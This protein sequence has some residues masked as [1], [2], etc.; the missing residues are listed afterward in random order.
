M[1]NDAGLPE[2]LCVGIAVKKD[3]LIDVVVDLCL[4]MIKIALAVCEVTKD[5]K[6]AIKFFQTVR[7]AADKAKVS[8]E[9]AVSIE[10][11]HSLLGCAAKASDLASFQKAWTFLE[12]DG[13]QPDAKCFAMAFMCAGNVSSLKAGGGG[14]DPGRSSSSSAGSE[15]RQ[16]AVVAFLQSLVGDAK[17]LSMPGPDQIL[18]NVVDR[19]ERE[20][21]LWGLRQV[22]PGCDDGDHPIDVGHESTANF[23]PYDNPLLSEL[24]QR[25]ASC[26]ASP[27]AGL[28]GQGPGLDA[29][30]RQQLGT[31]R[32]LQVDVHSIVSTASG[33]GD[34]N[35]EAIDN[36]G[37]IPWEPLVGQVLDPIYK[38]INFGPILERR[39]F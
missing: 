20:A 30:F 36:V 38:F 29:K 4:E 6:T 25:D 13:L 26:L 3:Q 34:K 33:D 39:E 27:L 17:R 12:T 10:T 32:A 18:S 2:P 5:S 31:E 16:R 24:D 11:Y 22:F 9:Y 21:V 1:T 23:I 8:L 19:C 7:S 28:Y 35:E 37:A 14:S 15:N